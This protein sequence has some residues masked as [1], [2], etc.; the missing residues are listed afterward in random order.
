[1]NGFCSRHFYG[2]NRNSRVRKLPQIETAAN[3]Q[4]IQLDLKL[5]WIKNEFVAFCFVSCQSILGKWVQSQS[6]NR[7]S[8]NCTKY[9]HYQ[10]RG[11][12]TFFF[13]EF[14]HYIEMYLRRL[15]FGTNTNCALFHHSEFRF[16]PLISFVYHC[17]IYF[18]WERPFILEQ[19]HFFETKPSIL[20]RKKKHVHFRK[21]YFFLFLLPTNC[22]CQAKYVFWFISLTSALFFVVF[23]R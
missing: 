13:I 10:F 4:L 14:S 23:F 19:K 1:M 20:F 17:A 3:C 22:F 11:R 15:L 18:N 8:I 9:T 5:D 6:W 7:M 2:S 21:T 12:K 16:T